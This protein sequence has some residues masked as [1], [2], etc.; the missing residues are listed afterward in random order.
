ML[1]LET[2]PQ[3]TTIQIDSGRDDTPVIEIEAELFAFKTELGVGHSCGCTCPC[4][5]RM[6]WEKPGSA[7]FG[8]DDTVGSPYGGTLGDDI[9]GFSMIDGFDGV[10]YTGL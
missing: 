1:N 3:I 6:P 9:T 5:D 7:P 10:I 4:R 2:T 8:V